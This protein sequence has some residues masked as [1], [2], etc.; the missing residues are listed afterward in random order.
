[1]ALNPSPVANI[2]PQIMA[3]TRKGNVIQMVT[4]L[5]ATDKDFG[6]GATDNP[7]ICNI[8]PEPFVNAIRIAAV[9]K[10]G[11]AFK[12]SD[13]MMTVAKNSISE[14]NALDQHTEW[15]VNCDR[16]ETIA[17]TPGPTAWEFVIRRKSTSPVVP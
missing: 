6:M 11:G 3:H 8:H 4:Y 14:A 13:L 7:N 2:F 10:S 16:Y 15:N 5:P 9:V 12:F 17:V 1:M